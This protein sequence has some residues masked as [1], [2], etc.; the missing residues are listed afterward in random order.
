MRSFI[1][2][3]S[4]LPELSIGHALINGNYKIIDKIGQGSYG[5]VY[6]VENTSNENIYACKVEKINNKK[7]Q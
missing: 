2:K 3:E 1:R 4:E 7:K 5:V 6:K